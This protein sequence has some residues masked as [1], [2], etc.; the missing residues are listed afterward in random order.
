M[1]NQITI[2]DA[3]AAVEKNP[4]VESEYQALVTW[5]QTRPKDHGATG[6]ENVL[7]FLLD[8]P[9]KIWW[10]SWELIGKTNSKGGW[11]SH[12]AP[13]RASDLAIHHS[14]LVEDRKIGRF[15]VYRLRTENLSD[16]K[17]FL[18]E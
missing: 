3:I 1:E 4:T 11:L 14:T 6:L 8:H 12:R 13:A 9:E 5:Y 17:T 2:F 18:G 7:R 16:I 10:F 15:S